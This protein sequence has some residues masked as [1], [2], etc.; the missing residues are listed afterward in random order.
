LTK[1]PGVQKVDIDL[2]TKKVVVIGTASEDAV[3]AALTKAGKPYKK[4]TSA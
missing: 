3:V 1:T 4:A 2:G